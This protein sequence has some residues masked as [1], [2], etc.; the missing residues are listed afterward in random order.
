MTLWSAVDCINFMKTTLVRI[1]T[2]DKLRLDGLFFEPDKKSRIVVLH[3]HG[4]AGNFYEN[5]FL[6]QMAKQFTDSGYA[7]LSGNTRGHDFIADFKIAGPKEKYK[8]VGQVYEKFEDCVLDIEAW[9]KFL[10]SKGYDKIILQGHSLGACKAVYYQYKNSKSGIKAMV[11]A[12]PPDMLGLVKKKFLKKLFNQ[13]LREAKRLVAQGKGDHI[14]SRK[15]WGWYY[16]SAKSFL[17]IF[18]DG[19]KTDVFPILRGGSFKELE[20]IKIPIF[21][22]YGGK[23][24]ATVFSP[25]KDL[26]LLDKHIKSN[27]SKTLIIDN[28]SHSYFNHEKEVAREVTKWI[29]EI[30]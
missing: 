10:K 7:F 5:Y 23:D 16:K 8:R 6:D 9:I 17:N 3:I 19:A 27:N 25:K 20:S 21:A 30:F 11:L 28:A 14:L 29:K 26:V 18:A 13:F 1:Y 2:S 24:D 15:I 4:M 12:S 22:F